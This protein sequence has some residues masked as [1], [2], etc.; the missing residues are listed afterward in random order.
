MSRTRFRRSVLLA[1]LA[2]LAGCTAPKG[3]AR[4]GGGP[5]ARRP[6]RTPAAEALELLRAYLRIDTTNPPGHELRAAR[7]LRSVLER[8]GIEA[9]IFDMGHDRANLYA[10]LHGDGSA[11]PLV[12]LHHMDVVPAEREYWSVPPF[13]AV[14]K[15]GALY[16][17]GAVDIKG[18]GIIDLMTLLLLKRRGRRLERDVILLGVADEE[19]GSRGTL[20]MVRH[21]RD[22]LRGA[23]ILIDEGAGVRTDASGKVIGYWVSVAEKAPLWLT[24]RFS[25]PSG[26]GSRPLRQSAVN[27]AV[28]AAHRI[29]DY[30]TP[31]VVSP[32]YRSGL[33]ARVKRLSGL[34]QL[35][36][37]AGDLRSSLDDPSF[38]RAIA[39]RDPEINAALRDTISITQLRGSDKINTIANE[40][41]LGLDCRL[42]PGSDKQT[43]IQRLRGVV[44][45]ATMRVTVDE[46]VEPRASPAD[47][48]FVRALRRVAAKRNPGVPVVTD[49]LLSST[50]AVYYRALGIDAYGFE[51]YPLSDA[52]VALSHGNDERIRVAALDFGIETMVELVAALDR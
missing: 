24:L 5:P 37:Y 41:S 31:L 43:F 14:V 12:L 45:D 9:R 28:R 42:L 23:E 2:L 17:R 3:P 36:G 18:K 20:W 46:Y 35:P 22:L 26:H 48:P 40:A 29:I 19:Q 30:E 52:E 1:A 50:D 38:L 49:L 16:G 8:E 32:A 11:R 25:G 7:F 15:D 6:D 10:V 33:L 13:A 39:A 51:P 21:Q 4:R 47:G 34:D 44:G 27:R